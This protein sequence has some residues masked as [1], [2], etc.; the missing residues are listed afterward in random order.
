MS[1]RSVIINVRKN[2]DQRPLPDDSIKTEQRIFFSACAK[3]V[4]TLALSS[5]CDRSSRSNPPISHLST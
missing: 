2:K 5:C 3:F 1:I 4:V